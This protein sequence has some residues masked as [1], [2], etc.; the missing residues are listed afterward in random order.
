MSLGETAFHLLQA[1][2]NYR[3]CDGIRDV[4]GFDL[5]ANH[6]FQSRKLI[7]GPCVVDETQPCL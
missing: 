3:N 6:Q 1:C 7:L 2:L 4:V 5:E